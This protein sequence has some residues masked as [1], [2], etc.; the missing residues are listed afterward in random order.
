M[1]LPTKTLNATLA[2]AVALT[3]IG[4]A[5]VKRD[6]LA[7]ELTRVKDEMRAEYTEADTELATRLDG[8]IN[9]VSADLTAVDA[10]VD[11][12][13]ARVADLQ[14]EMQALQTEFGATITR[15]E[16]ALAFNVPVYFEYD[17]ADIRDQDRP[18]LDRFAGVIQEYYDDALITVEGFA[19][20]AG[21]EAYNLALGQ[22]R[23]ESVRGYL[24]EHGGL[25]PYRVRAVSYGETTER[26]INPEAKGDDAAALANRRVT[27]VV[28]TDQDFDI[29]VSDA[30]GTSGSE[31]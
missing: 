20:P 11:G 9:A 30:T 29:A 2:A 22:R 21:S 19:D 1:A 3:G 15:L 7:T 12:L 16:G 23:A 26:L 5:H 17:S 24:T 31:S 18:V 10:R 4:C 14:S 27:L 25:E 6:E 28:D 13:D 8:R